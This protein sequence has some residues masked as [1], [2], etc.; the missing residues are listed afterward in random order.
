MA[1][2]ET[3]HLSYGLV[4]PDNSLSYSLFSRIQGKIANEFCQAQKISKHFS[5]HPSRQNTMA[6]I[7]F[8]VLCSNNVHHQHIDFIEKIC[9]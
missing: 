2:L 8:S 4:K 5:I 1:L 3:I 6:A 7:V 9:T